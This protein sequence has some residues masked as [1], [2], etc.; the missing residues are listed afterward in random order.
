[1]SDSGD[2]QTGGDQ[3]GRDKVG[4]DQPPVE[5]EVAALRQLADLLRQGAICESLPGVILPAD[6]VPQIRRLLA[7]LPE[8]APQGLRNRLHFDEVGEREQEGS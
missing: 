4:R 1:V 3:V 6:A 8:A 2:T 7:L 5:A